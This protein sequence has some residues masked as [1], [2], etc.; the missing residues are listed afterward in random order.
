M[1]HDDAHQSLA[2]DCICLCVSPGQGAHVILD[3]EANV[4]H[5]GVAESGSNDA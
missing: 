1:Q 3:L 2:Y 4:L 5:V